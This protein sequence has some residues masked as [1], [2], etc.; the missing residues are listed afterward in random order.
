[1]SDDDTPQILDSLRTFAAAEKC[2]Q[3]RIFGLTR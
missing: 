3:V 2:S 1:V